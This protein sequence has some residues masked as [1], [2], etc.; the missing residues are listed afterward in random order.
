[1]V[2]QWRCL[3]VTKV[4]GNS[5][6]VTAIKET[7][8]EFTVVVVG[9]AVNLERCMVANGRFDGHIVQ[10]HVDGTGEGVN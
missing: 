6:W 2:R 4:E 5:H 3:T 8:I 1:M 10:G 9:D 7:W